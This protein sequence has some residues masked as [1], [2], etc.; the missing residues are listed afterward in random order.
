MELVKASE[1]K[2]QSQEWLIP[3]YLCDSLTLLS[4]EP[5]SGKTS[6]ACHLIRA[7][8]TGSEFLGELPTQTGLK[9]AYMGF[10][11]RWQREVS[12]RLDDVADELLFATSATYKEEAEWEQLSLLI[13]QN[14]INLLIIDHLYNFSDGADLDRQ[15][16][17]QL[18]LNPLMKLI[19]DTGAAVLLITQGARGQGGRSAHSVAIDGQARWLLRLS[20]GVK[21]KTLNALGNNS[22]TKTVK[23]ALS[24]KQLELMSKPSEQQAKR[25]SVREMANR[26]RFIVENAPVDATLSAKALGSWLSEQDLGIGTPESGRTA[27]NNLIKVGLLARKSTKGAIFAGP[28]L[29]L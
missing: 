27:V 25:D 6:L 15:N 7:L 12:E 28:K 10:D 2:E 4:G 26:A 17:V 3:G 13:K 29:A 1:W 21:V 11:F 9:I 19:N 18:V 5:K 20:A 24:P 16:Q 22:E 23:I 8:V 14:G